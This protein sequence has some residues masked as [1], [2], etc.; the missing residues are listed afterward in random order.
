MPGIPMG[1]VV[2]NESAISHIKQFSDGSEITMF[3]EIVAREFPHTSDYLDE[4]VALLE[5]E[6]PWMQCMLSLTPGIK[7]FPSEA[8]FVMCALEERAARDFGI[9]S[10]ADLIVRCKRLDLRYA[11][12]QVFLVLRE[13]AISWFLSEATKITKSLFLPCAILL[14]KPKAVLLFSV[15]LLRR[16]VLKFLDRNE[17]QL[18]DQRS[19]PGNSLLQ[20]FQ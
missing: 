19:S 18:R 3:N 6:I 8:N 14:M 10:A 13:S 11:T 2:G 9:S 12:W 1:Y 5:K 20:I 16:T 7:V 15:R 17:L 4:T